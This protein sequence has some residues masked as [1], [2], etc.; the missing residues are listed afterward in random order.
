MYE[1]YDLRTQ[2]CVYT[3]YSRAAAMCIVAAVPWL[4]F[5]E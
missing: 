2:E 4:F 3:A 5:Y 1:I